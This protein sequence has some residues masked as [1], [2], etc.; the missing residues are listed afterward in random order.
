M[1]YH[2]P[3]RL[4]SGSLKVGQR[5]Y[6]QGFNDGRKIE[7][8]GTPIINIEP[9]KELR[10]RFG[11]QPL[12]AFDRTRVRASFLVERVDRTSNPVE[13]LAVRLDAQGNPTEERIL[14]RPSELFDDL[15]LDTGGGPYMSENGGLCHRGPVAFQH[16]EEAYCSEAYK[17]ADRPGEPDRQILEGSDALEFLSKTVEDVGRN[18]ERLAQGYT[19]LRPAH[20]RAV[21]AGR[22]AAEGIVIPRLICREDAEAPVEQFVNFVPLKVEQIGEAFKFS[23]FSGTVTSFWDEDDV[24]T[25]WY[26]APRYSSVP[27]GSTSLVFIAV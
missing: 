22:C 20:L 13:A 2:G 19:E 15:R 4:T 7:R 5:V 1:E 10:Y 21:V 18:W 26:S 9:R 12:D 14:F 25:I 16:A 3:E 8:D 11:K 6:A 17:H 23:G 24:T 27:D